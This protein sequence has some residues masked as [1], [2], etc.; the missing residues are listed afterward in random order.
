MG[1]VNQVRQR[2]AALSLLDRAMHAMTDGELAALVEGLGED[3]VA[4]LDR[5]AAVP[6]GATTPDRLVYLRAQAINGRLN[7]GLEQIA[8]VLTDASLADI[9]EQLGDHADAPTEEQL[10]EVLPGVV[11]RHGVP[12]VRLMLASAI[13]GEAHAAPILTRLLK[14]DEELKLPPTE[15]RPAAPAS[16]PSEDDAE[17]KALREQRKARR[18]EQQAQARARRAQAEQARKK[19]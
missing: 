8:T 5:I 11:E 14:H 16:A 18:K 10:R 19:R 4:A 1:L 13:A 9:I 15:P 2:L 12:T 17:R 3:Q 7:G 6:E